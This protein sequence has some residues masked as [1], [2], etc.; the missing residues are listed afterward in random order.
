MSEER[1]FKDWIDKIAKS[2]PGFKGYYKKE[3]R[4]E[5]DYQLRGKIA[6]KLKDIKDVLNEKSRLATKSGDLGP[7]DEIARVDKNLEKLIDSILYADYGYSGFFDQ[8]EI[9]LDTLRSIY[10]VDLTLM[11]W[12]RNFTDNSTVDSDLAEISKNIKT[13]FDLLAKRLK[14]V[15]GD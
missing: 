6:K 10:E 11:E 2:I 12:V 4:R 7:L 3:E 5:T 9:T 1:A 14:I 8:K 15:E 13:G